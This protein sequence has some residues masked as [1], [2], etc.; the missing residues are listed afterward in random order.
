MCIRDSLYVGP[1]ENIRG[2]LKISYPINHGIVD[3]WMDMK[4]IWR[5]VYTELKAVSKEHAILLSEPCNNPKS[6]RTKL[7]E[8]FF[9]TYDVP[10]LFV[11]QQPILSLYAFGRT[12]G[13]VME[14]GDGVTQ[15]VPIYEGYAIQ[16]AIERV[17]LGGRD[18]TNYFQLLLRR[19]GYNFTTSAEFEVVRTMKEITNELAENKD[20]LEEVVKMDDKKSQ[21][22]PYYLPDGS[23]IQL[24]SERF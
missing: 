14:S 9:E 5:H 6:N 7:A 13:L 4:A 23:S 12:T 17:D 20:S 21:P 2:L 16:N 1:G 10:A 24:A 19:R 15:C 3:D 8:T 22:T 11:A 18:I